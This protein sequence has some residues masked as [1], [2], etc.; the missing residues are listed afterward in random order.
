MGCLHW[1]MNVEF[2]AAWSMPYTHKSSLP[3]SQML[4]N[5]Q[6]NCYSIRSAKST[7]TIFAFLLEYW[8]LTKTTYLNSIGRLY[9]SIKLFA[10][11]LQYQLCL[12][13]FSKDGHIEQI[14]DISTNGTEV[15]MA[16]AFEHCFI[17]LNNSY[18]KLFQNNGYCIKL[19]LCFIFNFQMFQGS[20]RVE[21]LR[22]ILEI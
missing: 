5:L 7:K 4:T 18:E 8:E 20:H 10:E 17:L 6:Q 9:F 1:M 11:Y 22:R 15:N 13:V 2:M 14:I 19:S 16:W 21:I 12:L 3:P